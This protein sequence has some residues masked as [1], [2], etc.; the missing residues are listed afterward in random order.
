MRSKITTENFAG[1]IIYAGID[2]HKKSWTV[3]LRSEHHHL[4]TFSQDPDADQLIRYLNKNYPGASY[5]AVYEAGFS[6]FGACRKMLSKGVDCMVVHPM[7]IPR[8]N[9]DKIM[10]T[11]AIDS[12]KLSSLFF[13]KDQDYIH[14]PDEELEADRALVRQRFRIVRDL[15]RTKNRLKSLFFQMGFNIPK[16]FEGSP[17]RQWTAKY[18]EWIDQIEVSQLSLK[19][20][21]ERY[22]E[23]GKIQKAQ[24]KASNRML[25]KM[26]RKPRYRKDYELLRSIPGI[27]RLTAIVLLTQLGD[28]RRFSTLDKLCFYIGL[29]PKVYSTGDTQKTGKMIKR[30]RRELKIHL[31]ESAWIAVRKD[32][33][34]TS[35]Y[36]VLCTKMNK[37]K[38][39]IRIARKILS[40]VRYVLMNKEPYEI[41]IVK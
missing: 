27:G 39:I 36:N 32:P 30:G 38:A 31:I 37:N 14:I 9:K 33:A 3:T 26:S 4:K 5:K 35:K 25:V 17:S 13:D 16:C 34:L 19:W 23:L 1:Q 41:G 6:G 11:D 20:T 12:R 21:F 10:K 40:R 22:V 24:L 2:V 15:A 18:L 7:D 28:I 29:V 8:S